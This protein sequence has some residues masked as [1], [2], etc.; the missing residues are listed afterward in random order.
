MSHLPQVRRSPPRALRPDA[1]RRRMLAAA[2]LAAL[3]VLGGGTLAPAPARA[4]AAELATLQLARGEAGLT[5]DFAVR[6]QLP[7]AVEEALNRGVPVYFLAEARLLRNRWYWRDERVARVSRQWRVAY[8]PL[9][10]AWRVGLGALSQT[11]PTL[12]E[13][14]ALVSR[15]SGWKLADAAQ[16]DADSRYTVEFSWRLDT[17]QL[18][19]PMQIGLGGQGVWAFGVQRTLRLD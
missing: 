4:Q 2:A 10:G 7:P 19:G 8:Q 13:A 15:S 1:G 16:L 11:V 9:T 5:L 17:S 3:A 12:A 6:L 14:M 18:P